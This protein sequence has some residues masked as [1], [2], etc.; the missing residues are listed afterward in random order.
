MRS[1]KNILPQHHLQEGERRNQ[2][3]LF[4]LFLVCLS[5]TNMAQ[6]RRG[7][8]G[9]PVRSHD[10]SSQMPFW[11]GLISD[12]HSAPLWM[13][14]TIP[15]LHKVNKEEWS[16]LVIQPRKLLTPSQ[17]FWAMI[18]ASDNTILRQP[19]ALG[20][21]MQEAEPPRML[22]ALLVTVPLSPHKHNHNLI[23]QFSP[24][25]SCWE[26]IQHSSKAS[27]VWVIPSLCCN[28]LSHP[29][30][31]SHWW[32]SSV[33]LQIPTH[34]WASLYWPSKRFDLC[35]KTLNFCGCNLWLKF[36]V[37]PYQI[38]ASNLTGYGD[39]FFL[40]LFICQSF[41][42][43]LKASCELSLSVSFSRI[44]IPSSSIFSSTHFSDLLSFFWPCLDSKC[45]YP[46]TDTHAPVKGLSG[47]IC[48]FSLDQNKSLVPVYCLSY[49]QPNIGS[50]QK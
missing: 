7:L 11:G 26:F 44:N 13:L 20:S 25:Q 39:F 50:S 47:I 15:A 35:F 12:W 41:I 10:F 22:S 19:G 17:W 30:S 4:V 24:L 28:L 38:C 34:S 43:Y 3:H 48:F 16:F 27:Q 40:L 29:S 21:W 9:V 42:K 49:L 32:N 18:C 23:N 5:N 8:S 37:L 36:E 45:F 14:K 46:G 33:S 1:T 2:P 31:A 6:Q